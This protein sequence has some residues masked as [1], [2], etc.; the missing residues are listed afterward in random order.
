MAKENGLKIPLFNEFVIRAD[1][2]NDYFLSGKFTVV[3]PANH[4]P[5]NDH[6]VWQGT[7]T[8]PSMEI[9]KF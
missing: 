6:R 5:P 8:L 2:T 9:R 4:V 1:N 3:P 7:L